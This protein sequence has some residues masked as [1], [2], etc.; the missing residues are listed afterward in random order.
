MTPLRWMKSF[1]AEEP[2]SAVT[3]RGGKS[4]QAVLLSTGTGIERD[5]R[6]LLQ[7]AVRT[8]HALGGFLRVAN[9][10]ER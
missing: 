4:R 3:G 9:G 7:V 6:V 1:W 8:D 10:V 5:R 2:V